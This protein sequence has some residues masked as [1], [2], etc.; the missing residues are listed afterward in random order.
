MNTKA[1][2]RIVVGATLA[3]VW[4]TSIAAGAAQ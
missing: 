3:L 1:L 2:G 4:H